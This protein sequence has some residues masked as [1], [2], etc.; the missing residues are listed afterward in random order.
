MN[1]VPHRRDSDSGHSMEM[2]S[3]DSNGRPILSVHMGHEFG[4]LDG[5][6]ISLRVDAEL[7]GFIDTSNR[8]A[9]VWSW[10]MS[11]VSRGESINPGLA[12]IHRTFERSISVHF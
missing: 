7:G 8:L 6:G 12:L 5:H 9:D 10:M 2:S 11:E 3:W 1:N 4:E